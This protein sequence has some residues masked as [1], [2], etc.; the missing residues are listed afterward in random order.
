[1]EPSLMWWMGPL[2]HH[3]QD[4]HQDSSLIIKSL[5]IYKIRRQALIS[6]KDLNPLLPDL[7][8][9]ILTTRTHCQPIT[10]NLPH[11]PLNS[12]FYLPVKF[13]PVSQASFIPE[14]YPLLFVWV[15]SY[16]TSCCFM[17]PR[18]MPPR[19]VHTNWRNETDATSSDQTKYPSQHL[20]WKLRRLPQMLVVTAGTG[21]SWGTHQVPNEYWKIKGR[22][23]D[24][25]S[26]SH[27]WQ[28]FN[29]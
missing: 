16:P 15:I 10:L 20:P 25:K 6:L 4:F 7:F 28:P 11:W 13:K 1:M 9:L 24:L 3:L 22:G 23:K 14:I 26:T 19:G 27:W 5:E 18:N 21:W 2:G 8:P 29:P 17:R 12:D